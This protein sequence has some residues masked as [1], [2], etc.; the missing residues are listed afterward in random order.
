VKFYDDR[1]GLTLSLERE[2]W[3]D[4]SSVMTGDIP[5]PRS[6]FCAAVHGQKMWVFPPLISNSHLSFC[7]ILFFFFDWETEIWNNKRCRYILGIVRYLFDR[8]DKWQ[9]GGTKL[10]TSLTCILMTLVCC[11]SNSIGILFY[12]PTIFEIESRSWTEILPRNF[13]IPS[14]SQYS[15]GLHRD[16][17][18]FFGGYCGEDKKCVNTLYKF[19]LSRLNE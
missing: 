10:D 6:R 5:S 19:Y 17:L 1:L 15:I 8:V 16:A 3:K 2:V 7:E 11:H 9:E 4:L 14:I 13:E 18:Y 12:W